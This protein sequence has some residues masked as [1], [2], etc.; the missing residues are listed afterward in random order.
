M[1]SS[2]VVHP[3]L[4]SI[5]NSTEPRRR[6][7]VPFASIGVL[8]YRSLSSDVAPGRGKVETIDNLLSNFSY[9]ADFFCRKTGDERFISLCSPGFLSSRTSKEGFRS[10][11]SNLLSP[12]L[13]VL[14][15]RCG[16][17]KRDQSAY[18]RRRRTRV[19]CE[20]FRLLSA[21]QPPAS[22]SL[23]T[24]TTL[25]RAYSFSTTH[26]Q[27]R[28]IMG[29]TEPTDDVEQPSSLN[30]TKFQPAKRAEGESAKMGALECKQ[31]E[32]PEYTT[33]CPVASTARAPQTKSSN[34][35]P[36]N[37]SMAIPTCMTCGPVIKNDNFKWHVPDIYHKI[38][39]ANPEAFHPGY[40][41]LKMTNS[42]TDSVEP[43]I[44]DDGRAVNWY[45][46]GPTVYDHAHLG[47]ARAY[48]TFDILRRIMEDYFGYE[49]F[50]QLNIT[51]IDDK[52][53]LRA[54]KNKLFY[55]YMKAHQEA[56]FTKPPG[57]S[58]SSSSSTSAAMPSSR[59]FVE[60]MQWLISRKDEAYF[61]KKK[62][63]LIEEIQKAIEEA[64]R[65][66]WKPPSEEEKT[67][68]LEKFA[69]KKALFEREAKQASDLL[70]QKKF[71][72]AAEVMADELK[73]W[74]DETV[75]S[76][77]TDNMVFQDH[78]RKFESSFWDDMLALNVRPPDAITRV[79]EYVPQIVTFIE[80]IIASGGAY[81]SNG[82]VYFDTRHFESR[83]HDYPKLGPKGK[84]KVDDDAMQEG[85][86]ALGVKLDGEKKD[87]RDFALWK[88]S[89]AGEPRWNSPWGLGRPGWHIE[90]SVMASDLMG[91]RL[92]IHGGGQDLKFP[93]HANE[94]AQS[95]CFHGTKQWV[96]YWTH[97]GTLNINNLKMSKSLKNFTTIKEA[98]ETT[99][100]TQIRIAFLQQHWHAKMLYSPEQLRIA[101]DFDTRVRNF[102]GMVK[103]KIRSAGCFSATE[104]IWNDEEKA[105]HKMIQ[106]SH[107]EIHTALL[108]NFN[109]PAVMNRLHEVI[110]K[111]NSYVG[112]CEKV[113]AQRQPRVLIL[114]KAASLVT[115]F[116]RL[117]GVLEGNDELGAA[118][119]SGE[120]GASREE[121][122]A[123]FLDAIA[124]FRDEIKEV[125]SAK[126][127]KSPA[128]LS[129]CDKLRDRTLV[130][131]GVE[132]SDVKGS[133]RSDWK[134]WTSPKDLAREKAG[135]KIGELEKQVG[136]IQ[137]VISDKRAALQRLEETVKFAT[138][139][140][141]LAAQ[142]LDFT[143]KRDEEGLPVAS[144]GVGGGE[145][146]PLKKSTLKTLKKNVKAYFDKRTK[147]L[148]RLGCAEDGSVA[149][150]VAA[151][152][153]KVET[154]IANKLDEQSKKKAELKEAL[155]E[156]QQ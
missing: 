29:S 112:N 91:P 17:C 58:T 12:Q 53:I 144:K 20:R 154:D 24:S 131:L 73:D 96:N 75:G 37:R 21:H 109:Y 88:K 90:C 89:K 114:R 143:E 39:E 94:M 51:D 139:E 86:G 102:T 55:S 23:K 9:Q 95:E 57:T 19:D 117:F 41:G 25:I 11:G 45:V 93:H 123:P 43:F 87:N 7:L 16:S 156:L 152:R 31:N 63:K 60:D 153:E 135:K 83:D 5:A 6:A 129:V 104:Q 113:D 120:G 64:Q 147:E 36:S 65:K 40:C 125:A 140:D 34:S 119:G 78:A 66:G 82:S 26:L 13:F 8:A 62:E 128:I 85:E 145:P 138:T 111:C 108:N 76:D 122:L 151:E 92:D 67:E 59:S 97:A 126:E 149:E 15:R 142:E 105:L 56:E 42:L 69:L 50:Y 141:W 10:G 155:L 35:S 100:A 46:C 1:S 32:D 48:L 134:L 52:I 61:G 72:A 150:A 116:L 14:L 38:V 79:T 107:A 4:R 132:L 68:K 137:T 121:I 98:L 101:R 71:E 3:R 80:S 136:S 81:E 110:G 130:Q 127:T 103:Q 30:A 44:P 18:S 146:E 148:K 54:R 49:V 27:I 77:V 124:A 28:T 47:H 99:S 115:K 74:L 84:G 106:S 33:P 22:T 118:E 2:L 70:A 133:A